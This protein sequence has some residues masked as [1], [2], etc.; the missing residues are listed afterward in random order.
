MNDGKRQ[1]VP[2]VDEKYL[3]DLLHHNSDWVW[4]V[5]AQ[6]RYTWVSGVV[7]DLLGYE[8]GYVIGRTPFDF[9]PPGEAERVAGAFGEIVSQ[10]R[11]FSG[12]VNRNMRADGQIVVLETSGIPLFNDKGELTGYR[13]IDRNI[14]NLGERVLQLE[15]I[16]DT[17]PVA[18]CML[19]LDGRLVMSNKAMNGLLNI[20]PEEATHSH[21]RRLMPDV[22]HQFQDDFILAESGVDIP[23]REIIWRDR[24]YDTQPVA[25]YNASNRVVGLSVTWVDITARREAEQKLASANQVLQQYAQRDH[26]TGLYNRRYMD[27]CL[28]NEINQAVVDGFPLSVCLAD[29]DYFKRYNDNYGHQSGDNCL[30]A[31]AKALVA[32]RRRPEDNVSRYGGEEFLVILPR[33][34]R[35]DALAEAEHLRENIN[36]LKL[37]HVASP[38]G[39]LTISIGVATLYACESLPPDTPLHMIASGLIHQADT[40][41][42]AA[43]NRGRNQVVAMPENAAQQPPHDAR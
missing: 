38:T 34:D 11:A 14:S 5:D 26:L 1:P 43:K 42:Y 15:T 12:L 3:L 24:C 37:P 6:G 21:F 28:L 17:T 29:I 10:Q 18:L 22:W 33:T 32:S 9:M 35:G 27:E 19:D 4:E 23:G 31:V 41:L 2:D 40:A 20:S 16:Y 7:H 8:P 13:G 25:L 30:R 39:N 36:A